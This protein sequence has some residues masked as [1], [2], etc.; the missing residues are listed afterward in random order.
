MSFRGKTT[1]PLI[2][3][4]DNTKEPFFVQGSYAD[5]DGYL[6]LPNYVYVPTS[7]ALHCTALYCTL[8]EALILMFP[9]VNQFE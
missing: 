6:H 5:T 3:K 7:T 9:T 4:M 2:L 1:I 8:M